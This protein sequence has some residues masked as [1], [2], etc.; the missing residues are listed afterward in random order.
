MIF[1]APDFLESLS[2]DELDWVIRNARWETLITAAT[3]LTEGT[4]SDSIYFIVNGLFEIL[5]C[6][7]T[8]REQKVAQCGPGQIVGE[9]SWLN[10]QPA[11]ATV[12][13]AE[14][15]S[16]LALPTSKLDEKITGDTTFALHLYKALARLQSERLRTAA[17]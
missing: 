15:S 14:N 4:R 6:D 13:A 17:P 5:V 11:F 8:G 7:A 2:S 16:V 1:Q 10:G 3:L 12:K 9:S